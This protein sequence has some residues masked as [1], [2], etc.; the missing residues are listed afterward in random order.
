[1]DIEAYRHD[2]EVI[3]Q[4]AALLQK[5][6]SQF[7]IEV[8]FSGDARRAYAELRAGLLP[9]VN[10]L[11]REDPHMLQSLLYRIDVDERRFSNAVSGDVEGAAERVTHLILEKELT[12]AVYRKM[13]GADKGK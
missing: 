1:M 10:R 12:K 13:M 9:H 6:F 3:R 2:L 4:A 7:G 5:D 11:L 8:T